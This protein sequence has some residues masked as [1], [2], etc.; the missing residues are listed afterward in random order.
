MTKSTRSFCSNVTTECD[1]KRTLIGFE[2]P[3]TSFYRFVCKQS[4]TGWTFTFD[5]SRKRIF[6]NLGQTSVAIEKKIAFF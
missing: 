5:G 4:N 6:N 3:R 1:R 2:R